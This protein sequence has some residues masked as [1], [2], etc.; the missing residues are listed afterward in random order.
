MTMQKEPFPEELGHLVLE[1]GAPKNVAY[2]MPRRCPDVPKAG[3]SEVKVAKLNA[4]EKMKR[5]DEKPS[6]GRIPL[7]PD[8]GYKVPPVPSEQE[9]KMILELKQEKIKMAKAKKLKK[10]E[11]SKQNSEIYEKPKTE[12]DN[13]I[14]DELEAHLAN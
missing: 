4:Q 12:K 6:L 7:P 8:L 2:V 5:R 1:I 3:T 11:F 14:L 13:T 9:M 10:V